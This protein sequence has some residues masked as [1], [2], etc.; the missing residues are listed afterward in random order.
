VLSSD[1]T[2]ARADKHK[3]RCAVRHI[4]IIKKKW[5]RKTRGMRRVHI[6]SILATPACDDDKENRHEGNN[7]TNFKKLNNTPG[8]KNM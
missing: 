1:N 8:E 6:T 5:P 2:E 4:Q 3:K 7:S